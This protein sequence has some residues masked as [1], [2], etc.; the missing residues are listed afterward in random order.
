MGWAE[1][2][3]RGFNGSANQDIAFALG[4]KT[5]RFQIQTDGDCGLAQQLKGKLGLFEV[6]RCKMHR[7]SLKK[8]LF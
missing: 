7:F 3:G 4:T 8:Y 2:C 1:G 5:V 6:M